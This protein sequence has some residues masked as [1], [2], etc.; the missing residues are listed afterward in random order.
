MVLQFLSVGK[1]MYV[2]NADAAHEG[3][4]G[5]VGGEGEESM[6]AWVEEWKV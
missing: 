2:R 1:M 5:D 3:D 6:R 4:G